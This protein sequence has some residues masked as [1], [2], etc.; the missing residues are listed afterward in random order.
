[1]VFYPASTLSCLGEGGESRES[2][3]AS[4][5]SPSLARSREAHF[6]GPDRRACSQAN[7]ILSSV[8]LQPSVATDENKPPP[9]TKLNLSFS[10]PA[11]QR[12]NLCSEADG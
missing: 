3:R 10:L 5:L 8:T 1:M 7:G 2:A 4:G 9:Q 6:A 11:S 12:R